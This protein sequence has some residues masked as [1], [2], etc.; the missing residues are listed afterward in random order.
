MQYPKNGSIVIVDDKIEDVED[1]IIAFSQKNVPTYYFSGR[2]DKLHRNLDNIKMIF[3]DAEYSHSGQTQVQNKTDHM[4]KIITALIN[5]NASDYII[6]TWSTT[7]ESFRDNLYGRLNQIHTVNDRLPSKNRIYKLPKQILGIKKGDVK[8]NG[9]FDIAL[10]NEKINE[11]LDESDILNLSIE[12]ENN[13]LQS[14]KNVL[15][16]FENVASSEEEQKKLYALFADSIS[17]K[18]ILDAENILIPALSPISALLSDQLSTLN[19]QVENSYIGKQLLNYINQKINIATVAKVNTFYHMDNTESANHEPGSVF[20]Y[21]DYMSE[22]SCSSNNCDT[23]WSENLVDKVLE[24][25]EIP[26]KKFSSMFDN[27]FQNQTEK[28]IFE[29]LVKQSPDIL[30]QLNSIVH[31][32]KEGELKEKSI[33]LEVQ[34]AKEQKKI[35][36]RFYIEKEQK[37]FFNLLKNACLPVFLEFSPDCDFVQGKRKKL[38]LIFG[39]LIPYNFQNILEG[40]SKLRMLNIIGDNIIT[41]PLVIYKETT[42]QVV[43][44]LHTVTGINEEAFKKIKSIFRF[45]KELLVDVQQKIASHISRPGFFNMNDYLA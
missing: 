39:L 6:I 32:T 45:R 19:N 23:K 9:H 33:Y 30:I 44:D 35:L 20:N 24:K 3:L 21:M 41:A 8:Q 28:K 15:K 13:V 10:I 38:R 31:N 42:Y 17:K 16:N 4:A 11:V 18:D 26:T 14:A 40:E 29:A 27:K 25:L 43:F 1:L 12:W 2:E 34:K 7:S 22:Y 5:E 37:I 36:K